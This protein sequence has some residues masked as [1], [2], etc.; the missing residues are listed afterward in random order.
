MDE[1][2]VIPTV[3]YTILRSM[4]RMEKQGQ[5]NNMEMREKLDCFLVLNGHL[6][7]GQKLSKIIDDNLDLAE[8]RIQIIQQA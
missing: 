1:N 2:F 7:E 3:D 4:E 6:D 8:R 5:S